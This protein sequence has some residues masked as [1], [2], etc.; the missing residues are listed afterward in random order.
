MNPELEEAKKKLRDGVLAF[1]RAAF[2]SS[3]DVTIASL[4]LAKELGRVGDTF[5]EADFAGLD[6]EGG[7]K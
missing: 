5:T 1:L 7:E 3:G 4:M 2:K 6:D